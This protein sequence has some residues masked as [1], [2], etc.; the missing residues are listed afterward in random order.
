MKAR[1]PHQG[2]HKYRRVLWGYKKTPV[3]R[4]MLPGCSH[5]VHIE[6]VIGRESVC[7]HCKGTFIIGGYAAERA[8]PKCDGCR[9]SQQQDK[10]DVASLIEGL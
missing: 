7:W 3:Y 6:F 10:L 4:C 1:R 9:G 8:K 5:Y 2:P